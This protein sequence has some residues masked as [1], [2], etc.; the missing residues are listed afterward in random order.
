M[1]KYILL[2]LV[3]I[4]SCST[5]AQNKQTKSADD[6]ARGYDYYGA[7]EAYLTLV[8]QG[9][10][11]LYIKKQLADCYYYIDNF[12]EAEK[13][14]DDVISIHTETYDFLDRIKNGTF[15]TV[16]GKVDIGG[17]ISSKKA[18]ECP[19]TM[20][21][22]DDILELEILATSH[23]HARKRAEEYFEILEWID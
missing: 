18:N 10:N 4:I 19:F 15:Y 3:A 1:K 6:L 7:I 20:Q 22:E 5:L 11:D 17:L 23:T 8:R 21:L 16:K 12:K 13:W 14:Y 2:V 9:N